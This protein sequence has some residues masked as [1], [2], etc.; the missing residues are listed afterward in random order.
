MEIYNNLNRFDGLEN[1]SSGNLNNSKI[2][3]Y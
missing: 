2:N 1:H 3:N